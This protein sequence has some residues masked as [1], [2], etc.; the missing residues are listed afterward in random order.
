MSVFGKVMTKILDPSFCEQC[1]DVANGSAA[2]IQLSDWSLCKTR[3]AVDLIY[4]LL[5][6]SIYLSMPKDLGTTS[7]KTL[8]AS[9]S[10]SLS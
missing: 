4:K 7:S 6:A 9:L 8:Q 2:Y 1:V 3:L 10:S 5:E